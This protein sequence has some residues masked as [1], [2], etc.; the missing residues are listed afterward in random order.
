MIFMGFQVMQDCSGKGPGG[1]WLTHHMDIGGRL[2]KGHAPA[3]HPDHSSL[4]LRGAVVGLGVGAV[5]TFE[6]KTG[7]VQPHR[8]NLFSMNRGL[9]FFCLGV[10]RHARARGCQSAIDEEREKQSQKNARAD[11]AALWHTGP[12]GSRSRRCRGIE[13]ALFFPYRL[14]T[15]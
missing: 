2:R 9:A 5:G 15:L 8:G 12:A 3:G 6:P 11:D 10:C 1:W 7:C 4:R 13:E 14:A